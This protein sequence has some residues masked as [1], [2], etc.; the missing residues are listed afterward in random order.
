MKKYI[1]SFLVLTSSLFIG[2]QNSYACS[3]MTPPSPN[4]AKEMSTSVF[5]WKVSSI[6]EK[7]SFNSYSKYKIKLSWIKNIKWEWSD[8]KTVYTAQSSAACWY[9]FEEWKEYIVYTN[10]E[11]WS[12]NVS[13]CSRTSLTKNA[14]KDLNKFNDEILKNQKNIKKNNYDNNNNKNS[15]INNKLII[16]AVILISISLFLLILKIMINKKNKN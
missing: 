9:N 5:I 14:E 4:E 3:C 1:L 12:Q 2:I 7:S 16:Y 11:E 10:W 8:V 15:A 6:E 13:L